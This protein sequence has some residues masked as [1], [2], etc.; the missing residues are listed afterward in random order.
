V[1][2][3]ISPGDWLAA[4]L[5]GARILIV[6]DDRAQCAHLARMAEEW[7][8]LPFIAQTLSEA[9]RLHRESKP[10]LVLLDVMMP[11]VDGYKLAQMFKRDAGFVP[12][13][14]LTALDDI[15]SKRRGLAA[16]ADEFLIKPVNAFELQIRVSSMLRIKR[17]ADEL[18]SAN[19]RLASLATIDSLTQLANRRVL[20]ERLAHEFARGKRYQKHLSCLL[21]D[22]DHFKMV[23][24]TH[25]HPMG[26]KVLAE[27][28]A[29][30]TATIRNTDLGGRYGGEEFMIIAPET[31]QKQA[32]ILGER[33]RRAISFR[34][35]Q[36]PN[37]P[38]VTVSIG[39][40]STETACATLDDLVHRTDEA[41]YTAKREGR[42]RVVAAT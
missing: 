23:N 6:D 3:S 14:L 2:I 19:R 13:I 39:V 11:H 18:E 8:S 41:L 9:L 7:A 40:A 12:I 21:L 31:S 38:P 24:D 32:L 34:T 1:T 16:G 26:D 29:A 37:L 30:I 17:L 10:D 25:G 42:D 33:L 27:V 5:R 4:S 20:A 15:E 35:S 28:G 36:D 22:I